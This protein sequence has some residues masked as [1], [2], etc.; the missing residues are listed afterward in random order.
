MFDAH[1][2]GN[3]NFWCYGMWFYSWTWGLL[4]WGLQGSS[5]TWI[6]DMASKEGHLLSPHHIF[7]ISTEVVP[8]IGCVL[9]PLMDRWTGSVANT[10]LHAPAHAHTCKLRTY[11]LWLQLSQCTFLKYSTFIIAF[12]MLCSVSER[13]LSISLGWTLTICVAPHSPASTCW[14][15]GICWVALLVRCCSLAQPGNFL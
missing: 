9:K 8:P 5:P 12:A 1:F 4:H 6:K 15:M 13:E 14:V 11:T 3:C 10:T 7:S 2:G